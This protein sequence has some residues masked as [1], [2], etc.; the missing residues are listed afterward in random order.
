[1]TYLYVP[2]LSDRSPW[3]L[4]IE[5]VELENVMEL[6]VNNHDHWG[7]SGHRDVEA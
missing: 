5:L 7:M 3:L 4:H 1:L 2:L 6:M